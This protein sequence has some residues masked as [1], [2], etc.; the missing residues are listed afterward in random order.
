MTDTVHANGIDIAYRFDGPE[1]APLVTMSNSLA[2]NMA[3]WDAQV[4]ALVPDFRVLR[5]D[6]RGHGATS[7]PP[8]PYTMDTLAADLIAL[9]DALGIERCALVGLSLGGMIGQQ[10]GIAHGERV[11]ALVLC[12]TLSRW[13]EG[14]GT[15]W[16]GRIRTAQTQGVKVLVEG[17]LERWFTPAFL[18]SG[19]PEIAR[20][21]EMIGATPAPGYIGC[22]HAIKGIDFLDRLGEIKVP[23]LVIAGADDP[24]TPVSAARD[25]QSHIPGAKLVVIENAAHLANVEQPEAFN[26]ALRDF[27]GGL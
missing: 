2:S 23:T 10:I 5:Y 14:A 16:D 4:T 25:I 8:A 17:T 9:W 18:K 13:P 7:A 3:M 21:G 6:T 11:S 15:I 26:Q 27:L 1:G 24:A 22:S 20:I 19:S 12:D